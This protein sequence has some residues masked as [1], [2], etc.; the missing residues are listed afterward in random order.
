MVEIIKTGLHDTIQDLGRI[1]SQEYGVPFSG[2]MDSYSATL[3][4]T[5][6]GN[7][8]NAAV[9]EA[10]MYGPKIKFQ[11]NTTIC[12][13]GAAMNAMLNSSPIKNNMIISVHK[14]DLL[15]FGKLAYGFRVYIAVFGGFLTETVMNSR[16]MYRG[17]TSA[18]KIEKGNLLAIKED[19]HASKQSFSSVKIDKAH[20]YD[21]ELDVFK[22]PEFDLLTSNQQN[23]LLNSDFTITKDSN[24]MAYQFEERL[25]NS[26]DEIITSL[27]LPGTVQLTPSGQLLVLMRDCQITGGY[28]RVLQLTEASVNRLSQKV[29]GRKIRL[30]CKN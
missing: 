18:S 19:N 14:D 15:S 24:R 20:F 8:S 2:V 13:T 12:I 23:L 25:E 11:V 27:V 5:I 17:I 9:I 21:T 10:V 4:N 6:L 22:G 30:K 7:D 26:L 1:G 28:P 3:A 16:S 29:F